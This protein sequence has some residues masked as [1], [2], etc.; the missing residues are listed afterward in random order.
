M[1]KDEW[2][3]SSSPFSASQAGDRTTDRPGASVTAPLPGSTIN[4][5]NVFSSVNVTIDATIVLKH[6]AIRHKHEAISNQALQHGRNEPNSR[7]CVILLRGCYVHRFHGNTLELHHPLLDSLGPQVSA[8]AKL[9][10][11]GYWWCHLLFWL[12]QTFSQLP[13]C[14]NTLQTLLN[15]AVG[16]GSKLAVQERRFSSF[17][18]H[19]ASF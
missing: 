14:L 13:F 12:L 1:F 10:Y 8:S 18:W 2:A 7:Q 5:W 11:A 4:L 19:F 16:S 3:W 15:L 6:E 17:Q 9:H